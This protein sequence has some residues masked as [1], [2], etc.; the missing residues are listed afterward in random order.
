MTLLVDAP[1]LARDTDLD[2]EEEDPLR[3]EPEM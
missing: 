2:D 3:M 1:V